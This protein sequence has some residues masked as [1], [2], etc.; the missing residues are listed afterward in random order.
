MDSLAPSSEE[1]EATGRTLFD[2][3]KQDYIVLIKV[4]SSVDMWNYVLALTK[5]E[6]YW[7]TL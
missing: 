4:A 3:T 7:L 6:N 1:F 5:I 2:D